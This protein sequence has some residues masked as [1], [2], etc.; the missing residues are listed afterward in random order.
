MN[1]NVKRVNRFFMLACAPFIGLFLY[2]IVVS[3]SAKPLEIQLDKASPVPDMSMRAAT[4]QLN[5]DLGQASKTAE[6]TVD[7]IRKVST[8]YRKT[9]KT[10]SSIVKSSATQAGRPEVIYD[11]RITSRLGTAI[12]RVDSDNLRMELYRIHQDTYNGYA[13]KIK[14]KNPKAMKMTLGKDKLG[15]AETTMQAVKRYG[16]IAGINAGGF[17]DGGGKRYPLSTTVLNGDYLNG[18]EAS[19][20]D[21]SFV[22]MNKNGKLIGGKFHSKS[23]LDALNPAFGATFV[24]TLLK[25]GSKNP[26]P[27]KWKSSPKRAPRTVIGSYKD[28]QILLM[29]IDG[30]NERGDSGATLEELQNKLANLGVRDA[31]NL[32]GGG[33]SSLIFNRRVVNHPSDGQLRPV[34]THFLFFK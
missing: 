32:D 11:R 22:G 24:P 6:F 30:Y 26:I 7:S 16:A 8:I 15:S 5:K 9:T 14:L 33:S 21:L 2:L 19:Y 18:F 10:M 17:A 28:D 25:N 4:E 23:E 31:F 13:V 20:K 1:L 27:D 29:V 12:E 34:P 3:L